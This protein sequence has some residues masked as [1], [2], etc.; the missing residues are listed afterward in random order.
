VNGAFAG[1]FPNP[2]GRPH[3]LWW[4]SP[5]G[6]T[7]LMVA[8]T[9]MVAATTT[10]ETFRTQFREPKSLTT[11]TMLLYLCAATIFV[12][13]SA[14]PLLR[15]EGSAQRP[16][17]KF[18]DRQL[19]TLIS[20]STVLYRLTILGYVAFLVVAIARGLRP[21]TV[22]RAFSQGGTESNTLRQLFAPVTG[23]TTLTEIGIAFVVISVLVLLRRRD[24]T[25][26]HRLVILLMLA[27][28]RAYLVNERLA[29]LELLVPMLV[30]LA[31][32]RAAVVHGTRRVLVQLAPLV[33]VP[34]L[35]L[36]F[37]V[38]EY[39]RS[40][41]FYAANA[42][43][44]FLRFG[45]QRLAGYYTTAYNNGQIS[46]DHQHF[47]GRLPYGTLEVL[48]TAPGISQLNLYA[49]LTGRDDV[50]LSND[51]LKQ[52]GNPEFNSPGG[53]ATPLVDYGIIGGFVFLFV[54]G[55]IL[56]FIYRDCCDGRFYAILMYPPLVTGLFELPRYIYW[57]QGRLA[58]AL[59]ALA[60]VAARMKSAQEPTA[61]SS[62][63][64]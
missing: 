14:L 57:T 60:F 12:V 19:G 29:L 27:L 20:A 35:V 53:L 39:S 5:L 22:F 41:K 28:A 33:L 38:F 44:S 18:S 55:L 25:T 32:D 2:V 59:V 26:L 64:P 24:H 17:Q 52:Y 1:K 63:S 9:L 16:R 37:S 23:V 51:L 31:L 50:Q 15:N 46:L 21:A 3:R 48:W 54:L 36:V 11:H 10:D 45:S 13:G 56:G 30:V 8:P 42:H 43:E 7:L 40:Y 49:A 58:V 61:V 6:V 4:I 47:S 62:R 34:I